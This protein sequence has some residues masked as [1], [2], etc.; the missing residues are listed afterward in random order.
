M[1]QMKY[2]ITTR[3]AVTKLAIAATNAVVAV[4]L[5]L[6]EPTLKA[7]LERADDELFRAKRA[8]WGGDK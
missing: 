5:G 1:D 8:L 4:A 6:D 3:D 7:A 2:D